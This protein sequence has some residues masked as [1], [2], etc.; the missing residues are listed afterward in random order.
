MP[1]I[2]PDG[3]GVFA[4]NCGAPAF[5]FTREQLESDIGPRLVNMVRNV[6]VALERPLE[7][8]ADQE[9]KSHGC[10]RRH[11]RRVTRDASPTASDVRRMSAGTP[12][13]R[14]R[15]PR[16]SAPLLEV[17]DVGV[18]FGGIVALDGVSFR[19]RERPD[20]LG[21]IGPNGAGKTTLFN[22][23]SRLYTPDRGDILF[24][25]RTHPRPAAAPHRRD[26]HR[27]HVPEPRAVPHA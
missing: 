5:Q 18:R 19:S 15:A 20:L 17:R 25:G 10:A 24:E 26:R 22:C 7:A 8:A 12:P 21:L 3:S 27:P 2:A 13:S 14:V 11:A 6:E 23:L 16:R 9:G 1:L 4:F